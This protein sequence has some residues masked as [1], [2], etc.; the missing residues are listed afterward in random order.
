MINANSIGIW[1][2]GTGGKTTQ[3]SPVNGNGF[4]PLKSISYINSKVAEVKAIPS[5]ARS[6]G[7]EFGSLLVDEWYGEGLTGVACD[8]IGKDIK[9]PSGPVWTTDGKVPFVVDLYHSILWKN[10]CGCVAYSISEGVWASDV[11]GVETPKDYGA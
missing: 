8:A 11:C 2:T 3:V 10:Q 5:M 4:S 7:M 1:S 6:Y 9:G